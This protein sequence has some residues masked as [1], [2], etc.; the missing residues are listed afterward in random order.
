MRAIRSL[1]FLAAGA[2]L[3]LVASSAGAVNYT[4]AGKFTS[5]R[6]KGAQVP[7]VGLTAGAAAINDCGGLTFMSGPGVAGTMTPVPTMT[8]GANS[9]GGMDLGCMP[10]A[11]GKNVA[12]TGKGVGGQFTLPA[13]AFKNV[14]PATTIN[15][16]GI[17]TVPGVLQFATDNSVTGPP[18]VRLET[19]MGT[20]NTGGNTAAFRVF[21]QGAWATQ[22]G[23]AGP[24]FTWC[25]GT[26]SGPGG[27]CTA[28]GQGAY[29]EI[30]KY[31]GTAT[32]F[33]GTMSYLTH[34]IN[35]GSLVQQNGALGVVVPFG[36]PGQNGMAATLA[37]G[38][39]YADHHVDVLLAANVHLTH[40]EATVN[41]PIVGPQKLVTMLGAVVG[42]GPAGIAHNW[43]FPLTTGTVLVRNTGTLQGNPHNTTF[44][45]MGYDCVNAKGTNCSVPTGMN[46]RNLSLVAGALGVGVLPAPVGNVPTIA[47][48]NTYL[49]EPGATLQVL[50][51]VAGLLGIAAWRSRRVR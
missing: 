13:G 30:I 32:S 47:L 4:F 31:N 5:N 43:G 26:I 3:C 19:P 38:R 51:G 45:A 22:T 41:R 35:P 17:A 11:A 18:A 15:A 1:R 27:P 46:Q 12:S 20:M 24:Q 2:A 33:G 29:P 23:R 8:V 14:G 9:R 36:T 44:T 7:L 28:I 48:V 6:G 49:P 16:I 50:A 42:M 10:L 39:G 25:P 21:K 34:Q 40:M 37:T